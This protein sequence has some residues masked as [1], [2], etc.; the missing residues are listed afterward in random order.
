MLLLLIHV[1]PVV[2]QS[3]N[4]GTPGIPGI[5]GTHGPNGLDGPKGDKGDFG[6]LTL[7]MKTSDTFSVHVCLHV[8]N[9]SDLRKCKSD[10]FKFPITLTTL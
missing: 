5:P 10:V 9:N 3:C 6:E 1:G 4:A 8:V 2:T 7:D